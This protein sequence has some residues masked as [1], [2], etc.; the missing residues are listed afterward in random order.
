[1]QEPEP[2]LP[3]ERSDPTSLWQAPGA[4]PKPGRG[5]Q[6][7]PT[8]LSGSTAHRMRMLGAVTP[9]SLPLPGEHIDS[10][11]LEEAIGVGGMGAVFRALDA[12]LDRHVAL[13]ILPPEQAGDS[14]VVQRFYQEGRAAARLDNENIARVYTIGH[15]DRYHYIA[16]EYIEG[17]TIRQR[18]ERNGPLPISEAINFTLQIAGAL[19]HAA[20]RGVVH[21]DIKPSNIIVTPQG[22]AKLVDM[23]L[24]RRF[25][26][27]CDDGLTQSGMTLGTFDYISPE[28]A[29]DPRDVDVRSDLYSLG[30]TLFHMLTGRPPFPD[31]TVLQKLLQHQ[32]DQP[33]DVRELNPDVPTDL[34]TILVKLMAKD[35]DRRYQTPEQL[36]RDLLTVAGA[37]GLRSVSPEGLVWMSAARPPG[38]ERHLVWGLPALA[39]SL[40]VLVLIWWGQEP[41]VPLPRPTPE[42]DGK[43]TDN[44]G[45]RRP[46]GP[47][48]S[49]ASRTPAGPAEATALAS[50]EGA[51]PRPRELTVDSGDDLLKV[52]ASAPPRS[53]VVLADDGPYLIGDRGEDLS[54]ARLH[55][56]DLTI[57]AGARV[58]PEIRLSHEADASSDTPS[59]LLDFVGGRVTLEGLV[60]ILEPGDQ[61]DSLAAVRTQDTELTVRRCLFRRR[62][63]RLWWG[64]LSALEV[65]G[66]W[67]GER[68]AAVA[69]ENSH[70]DG[71]QVG[72]LASG[73]ADLTLR[74]CT[75]AGVDPAVWFENGK[76]P[77]P[78]P[79]E[80]RL[81]HVSIAA[82]EGPIFRFEGTAPRVR[83]DDSLMAPPREGEATLVS[84]DSPASLDWRGRS[85]LY[86]RIGIFLQ[87]TGSRSPREPIRDW[88]SWESSLADVRESD[89]VSGRARVWEE[90]DPVQASS[91]D[92]QNPMRAFRLLATH[93]GSPA[94]GARLDPAGAT[95]SGVKVV[96]TTPDLRREPPAT[97]KPEIPVTA[98]SQP[99]DPPP[100]PTTVTTAS[101]DTSASKPKLNSSGMPEM[102]LMPP[103]DQEPLP[104]RTGIAPESRPVEATSPAAVVSKPNLPE[105]D[106]AIL[107]TADQ[108]LKALNQ[109]DA[110]GGTL[111][112]AA[113]ADWELPTATIR[114]NV[115]WVL[116]AEPGATRPRIRFRPSPADP[117]TPTARSVWL[118]LRSGSLQ[119]EGIDI[120][121]S[122]EDAPR[123][124]RWAVFGVWGGADL[125]LSHCT[126]TV[127]GDEV[128]S[129]IVV[130]PTG[131]DEVEE[132]SVAP[133]PSAA[134]IR[135]TDSL[136]RS[137][138]DMVDVAA[139]HRLE[140][141]LDDVIVSTG[142]S[143]VHA[144]G[145]PR[146]MTSEPIRISLT[147]VT[148]RTSGGL[149]Q[150][151]S[152]GGEPELPIADVRVRDSILATT[153]KGAPL[154]RVDGQ[155]AL[156]A[157][158]DR[159]KWEGHGVA[160]HQ[161]NAYRR[162]QSAQVGSVPTI[163]D[164]SSWVVA[165]GTK[166]ADPI[167]GDVKFLQDWDPDRPAWTLNRDDVR[168]ARDSPSPRAGADLDMIPDVEPNEP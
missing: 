168:L 154:F 93:A 69:I 51:D 84:T 50:A 48:Q 30:C 115:R 63:E 53:V 70:F 77:R 117:K 89:S 143:L 7:Q 72:V 149:V 156:S 120:V 45:G 102:P 41:G 32:E 49:T 38:W 127:E 4:T 3:P 148:A 83:I 85:N 91:R 2:F 123:V 76:A 42:R 56:R 167:H 150:L 130:V 6:T 15:D 54:T 37:L 95:A 19:V 61:E 8:V 34:A 78:V 28:Q 164:R 98:P 64:R 21:R 73:P 1:M 131:E 113:D 46:S 44:A 114:G 109:P 17:T 81:Q 75:M 151:E 74:D 116:R 27:G 9:T 146:G 33:P 126:V 96:T 158:R 14:E 35:R 134:V 22:R 128:D 67:S 18:V 80:L 88:S 65:R 11:E 62:G 100:R 118:E 162:D 121:L 71:G 82:G 10:F 90:T 20:E 55:D 40:V 140:L 163:Y 165:I 92:V 136:L 157:L 108:F 133:E 79:A 31:G 12:R 94:L 103:M 139:G 13:K 110:M 160:Y 124:G 105:S 142:G 66:N 68:P 138:G 107:R 86:N 59:A 145:L 57:K 141:E 166:E 52:L 147:Q 159:I 153:S 125:S 135:T 111:R 161:I 132:G 119:L 60:F 144:H 112:L 101:T 39:L 24:A 137:G 58:R 5:D 122:E 47:S 43:L 29:R 23:G 104:T 129:A 152:A 87:P 155:D 36:V 99:V 26:R 16:F 97:T 25:E 106:S